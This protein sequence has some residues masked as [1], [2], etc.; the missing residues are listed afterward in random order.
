MAGVDG[1]L[2][3]HMC[4]AAYGRW[5]REVCCAINTC[6][7]NTY[8]SRAESHSHGFGARNRCGPSLLSVDRF[9]F[10]N[11]IFGSNFPKKK[12]NQTHK[13]AFEDNNKLLAHGVCLLC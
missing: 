2:D 9:G 13:S 10:G 1:Y 5:S 4:A 8:D 3:K 11:A 7:K 12:P 6:M